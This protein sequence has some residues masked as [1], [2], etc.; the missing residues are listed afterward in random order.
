MQL[1]R[2]RQKYLVQGQ[3]DDGKEGA[4]ALGAPEEEGREQEREQ[5]KAALEMENGNG[6]EA[7][8]PVSEG[9]TGEEVE[10]ERGRGHGE[11]RCWGGGGGGGKDGPSL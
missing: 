5:E 1:G 9:V 2:A 11:E 3:L 8:E 4:V 10:A 7:A 6:L